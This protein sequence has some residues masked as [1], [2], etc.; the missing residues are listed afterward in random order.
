MAEIKKRE[1]DRRNSYLSQYDEY[2][3][4]TYCSEC[5]EKLQEYR[6]DNYSHKPREYNYCPYCGE[7]L[8]I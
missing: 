5:N 6:D 2:K 7:K 4:V 3:I 1:Y 8:H